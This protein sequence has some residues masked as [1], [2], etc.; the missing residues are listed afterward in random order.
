VLQQPDA[1]PLQY[2]VLGPGEEDYVRW[3]QKMDDEKEEELCLSGT[4]ESNK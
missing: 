4:A 1:H 2:T 3:W